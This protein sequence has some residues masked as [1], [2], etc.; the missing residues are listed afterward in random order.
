L[1]FFCRGVVVGGLVVY[2]LDYGLL[3][4]FDSCLHAYRSCYPPLNTGRGIA[5]KGTCDRSFLAG[6]PCINR[7]VIVSK[8]EALLL[9]LFYSRV[10][11]KV[12]RVASAILLLLLTS[13]YSAAPPVNCI[14]S[15]N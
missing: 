12:G 9:A 5:Y 11:K 8:C 2:A 15:T 14:N 1:D 10:R 4:V 3:T 13:S 7:V 6:E